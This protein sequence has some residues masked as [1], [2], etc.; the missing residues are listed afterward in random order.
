MTNALKPRN[1]FDEMGNYWAEIADKNAT[2]SQ[3]QLIKNVVN[4]EGLVLDLACGT[5]RHSI[6]LS[7]EGYG[8]VG[9]DASSNLLRIAKKRWVHIQLVKGDMRYL[10]FKSKAFSAA[11]SMDSSFGYLPSEQNDLQSLAEV[12]RTLESDG[13]F[14][15]DVFNREHVTRK[16]GKGPIRPSIAR[17]E[18]ALISFFLRLH[19]NLVK[20]LLFGFFKWKEYPSFYLF[21]KRAL[22]GKGEKIRDL[23]VI[24]DKKKVEIKVFRHI[25]RLYACE[26]LQVLLEKAGFFVCKV[27][28]SYDGQSFNADSNRLIV[29]ACLKQPLVLPNFKTG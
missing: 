10:P 9:L 27:Y 7:K 25:V 26:Q 23:W 22:V 15:L 11:I 4:T 28:G 18:Q 29:M 17:L 1:V 5:G 8:M 2:S 6:P 20:R 16:Y 24:C 13:L 21:Q 19:K 3:I 14:L 12:A